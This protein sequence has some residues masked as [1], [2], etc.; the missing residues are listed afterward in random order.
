MKKIL[1]VLVLILSSAC[2]R[3]V[4]YEKAHAGEK[5]K[6]LGYTL[7]GYEGYQWD[8]FCGGMVWHSLKRN[9]APGV[10]YSGCICKW[11]D[12]LMIYGPHVISGDLSRL[13]KEE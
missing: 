5:W 1:L 7:N 11:G 12:E 3:N 6:E 2:A 8:F 4:D 9:D 10:I 13:K